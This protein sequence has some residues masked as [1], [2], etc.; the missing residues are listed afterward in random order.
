[1]LYKRTPY[2]LTDGADYLVFDTEKD[3]CEYLGVSKCTVASCGRRHT[4]C[5]GYTVI[6]GISEES[7]YMDKRLHKIWEGMH[8]RCEYKKHSHYKDYGGRGI[9]VCDEWKEYL[10]FAKWAIENDYRKDLTIERQ[11]NNLGYSPSNCRWATFKE[12]AN[13]KRSN[14]IVD[15]EGIKMTISQCSEKYGIAKS[16]V[17]W[18]ANHNRDILTG[19]KMDEVIE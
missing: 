5:K 9:T 3:A 18:R 10:P 13:N 7:I 15:I 16:T 19:A 4:K 6:K 8:A 14:H 1:M 12:Q 11:D 17:R 2:I